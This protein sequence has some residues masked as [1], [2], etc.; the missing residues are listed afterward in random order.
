M[1]RNQLTHP[2]TVKYKNVFQQATFK[3]AIFC[4]KAKVICAFDF[5]TVKVTQNKTIT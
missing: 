3:S 4:D 1:E 5:Y 2:Q